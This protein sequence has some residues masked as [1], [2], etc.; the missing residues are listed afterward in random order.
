MKGGVYLQEWGAGEL[1]VLSNSGADTQPCMRVHLPRTPADS[2]ATYVSLVVLVSSFTL[3]GVGASRQRSRLLMWHA[4]PTIL[5][6][7]CLPGRTGCLS[8]SV[9]F[10]V[11]CGVDVKWGFRI[12]GG[13][14]HDIKL[15]IKLNTPGAPRK[16]R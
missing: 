4:T 11:D 3:L 13:V 16:L 8:S 2:Y 6:I 12:T 7:L 5:C 10:Q 14:W 15:Y 9:G 1:H